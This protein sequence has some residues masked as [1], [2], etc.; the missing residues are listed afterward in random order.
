MQSSVFVAREEELR[1]LQRSLDQVLAGQGQVCFVAGQAGSGKTA[2]IERFLTDAFGREASLVAAIG[3]CNAQT[4]ISDPYLPFREALTMLTAAPSQ[5]GSFVPENASRLQSVLAVAAQVLIEVAPDLIGLM[6]PG[7][8]LAGEVGKALAEKTGWTDHLKKQTKIGAARG[9]VL[10]QGR[11]FEQYVAFLQQLSQKAPLILFLDDLHWA[12]NPSIALLFHLGRHIGNQRIL[13]LGSYRPNDVALGRDGRPHPLEQVILELKRYQGEIVVD[14]DGLPVVATRSF[15]DALV[16]AEPNCLGDGFRQAL[17]HRTA[18][19]ALF[20]VELLQAMKER[21]D[22]M[23]DS[24]GCWVESAALDWNL[25]PAR[26]EGV[27]EERIGRLDQDLYRLLTTASVEGETFT[28]EV[29]AQVQHTAIR[30][31]VRQLTQDLERRHRLIS[32]QGWAQYGP[33]RLSRHRFLHNLFQTYLYD[34]ISPAERVYLHQDVGEALE[35]LLGAQSPAMAAQLA[36]HFDEAGVTAKAATYHVQAGQKAQRLSA[37]Q[38]AVRHYRRAE[39]LLTTLPEEPNTRQVEL[40]LQLSL[41]TTLIATEGYASPATER[42][43][44]RARQ[45]SSALN[46]PFQVLRAL[47]ARLTYRVVRAELQQAAEEAQESLALAEQINADTLVIGCQVTLGITAF[48]MGQFVAARSHIEQV[49]TL[50]DPQKHQELSYRQGQD[51][52][53]TALVYL[54]WLNWL[55]GQ[56]QQ[57]VQACASAIRAAEVANHP[58]SYALALVYDATLDL[59]L[60]RWPECA[61][62]AQQTLD[63]STRERFPLWMANAAVLHG[64]ALAHQGRVAEGI[65]E[66]QQGLAAWKATGAIL[67]L[68]FLDTQLAAVYLIAGRR[69]EGLQVIGETL[70]HVQQ[71]GEGWWLPE[72]HRLRAELLQLAPGHESEAEADLLK[73]LTIARSQGSR[74]LELR[75]AMSLAHLWRTQGRAAEGRDLLARLYASFGEGQDT[76]DHQAARSLLGEMTPPTPGR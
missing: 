30:G 46:D 39:E 47:A 40:E 73:A 50:F 7:A 69:D 48:H 18:G 5:R 64:A 68:V 2:L 43:F 9:E 14:L 54:G 6:A 10:D 1:R 25:L 55:Q 51:P 49:L 38:E 45:L 71:T 27:I 44:A 3:T 61:T 8:D 59:F 60:R 13:L 23:R 58:F 15:V 66:I 53:T 75:V 37:N 33:V 34:S 76:P 20:T 24:A 41:A 16:D 67:S 31:V 11:I 35:T 70:Q 63:I 72:Q 28:A 32:S 21:G 56:P 74:S 36:R 57:A 4:G 42:T 52:K 22:L 19:H 26:V 29:L 62:K 65:A 17:Y 12:D